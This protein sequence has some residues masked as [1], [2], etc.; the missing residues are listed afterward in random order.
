MS[1]SNQE[2]VLFLIINSNVTYCEC[3]PSDSRKHILPLNATR[4]LLLKFLP[5]STVKKSCKRSTRSQGV[6]SLSRYLGGP[7][8]LIPSEV[9][10]LRDVL[11]YMLF[12]QRF[13]ATAPATISDLACD[14]ADRVILAWNKSNSS[15]SS[16]VTITRRGIILR[17]ER[18]YSL[19]SMFVNQKQK[20]RK[21]KN[22]KLEIST[23]LDNL[24]KL[25]DITKC[26]CVITDCTFASP[27][28]NPGCQVSC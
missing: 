20:K 6:T 1:I 14:A 9:P 4:S 21:P 18:A 19:F 23:H 8:E 11:R 22:I 15:F 7:A 10:T 3:F 12:L 28:C 16:P 24:D 17:I 5:M 26:R 25:F 13:H 27:N 2:S